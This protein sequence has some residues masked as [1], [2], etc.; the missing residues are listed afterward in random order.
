[1][2]T[3]L[4]SGVALA[5]GLMLYGSRAQAQAQVWVNAPYW[6][7]VVSPQVQYYYIPEIDGYYDLY[8]QSYLFYDPGFGAWVSSPVLPRAY[9]GYDPRFFHPVVIEYVGRQPWGYLRD[10]QAYCGR[11]GVL[12]GRYYGANWPGRG[13]SAAPYGSYGPAYYGNRPHNQGGYVRNDY[14]DTRS[15]PNYGG[16]NDYRNNQNSYGNGPGTRSNGRNEQNLLNTPRGQ[17]SPGNSSN[18]S[19]QP[20]PN[21]RGRGRVM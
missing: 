3:L 11:W 5:L 8:A 19:G 16:R 18:Q 4:K 14:H 2:K 17:Q 1:M 12:P 21:N 13:Y 20:A 15:T 9:A 7:P 10:H 6:G